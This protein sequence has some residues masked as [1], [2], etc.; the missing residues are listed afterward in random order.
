MAKVE[1]GIKKAKFEDRILNELNLI[2]RKDLNDTRLQ[3]AS[4]TKVD[5][6][7]DYSVATVYWDT[8]NSEKRDDIK[9][10]LESCESKLRSSLS[11]VIKVR[12]TPEIKLVYDNQFESEQYITDLLGSE[13]KSGK[14]F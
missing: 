3:F 5:L 8:F 11:Q 1:K 12:H 2:L 4:L 14:S 6:S 7:N 13:I 10:A 9:V